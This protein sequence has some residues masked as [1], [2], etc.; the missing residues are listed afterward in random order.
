MDLLDGVHDKPVVSFKE[1]RSE[2]GSRRF[3]VISR[4]MAAFRKKKQSRDA[5]LEA[6]GLDAVEKAIVEGG[7]PPTRRSPGGKL[8]APQTER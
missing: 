6:R 8:K 3:D 4:A 1:T 7:T 2:R 5:I